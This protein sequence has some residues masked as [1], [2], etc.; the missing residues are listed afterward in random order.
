MK[1][2]DVLRSWSRILSGRAPSLSI[3]LTRECP[4]RCPG[5]YAYEE[6]HLGIPGLTLRQ[7]S[8]HKGNDLVHGVLDLIERHRPLHVSL[9]GGDPLVRFRELEELLP[10]LDRRGIAVQLVTSAFRPL[11]VRWTALPR[12]NIVVS[13]DGLQPEH[14]ARRKPATYE[15][16]LKNIEG[17]KVTIHCTITGQMMHRADYLEDFVRFWS[18]RKETKRI[19]LS[20]FTPQ[21]GAEGPEILTRE[22]RA[23]VIGD[24][25][26]LRT[27]Y[28][29]IDMPKALIEELHHPPASPKDCIFA[30]T[31][32]TVSADLKT[33]ITPCQFGGAP[34]CSQ[35]GCIASMAL[36]AVGHHRV[37]PG[38]T[39]GQLFTLSALVGQGVN[40]L[41]SLGGAEEPVAYPETKDQKAA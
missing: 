15:R 26:R 38:V 32:H 12:L 10:E 33:R 6:E 35:C 30:R 34:D 17:S 16:I 25:L 31:T 5:C 20:L 40:R 29:L 3:E 11:P 21:Q 18:E 4:L 36:A 9:V 14:D 13:V 19:W 22:E 24:L 1:T 37:V 27:V 8:D 23:R 7:L 39:A 2:S 28:P 41:R